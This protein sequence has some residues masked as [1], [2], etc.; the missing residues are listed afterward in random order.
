MYFMLWT[1]Y[2][3]ITFSHLISDCIGFVWHI[4]EIFYKRHTRIFM[5][6]S[7]RHR[8]NNTS[9]LF[10]PNIIHKISP[11]LQTWYKINFSDVTEEINALA[12]FAKRHPYLWKT[13][14]FNIMYSWKNCSKWYWIPKYSFRDLQFYGRIF[15]IYKEFNETSWLRSILHHGLVLCEIEKAEV[16]WNRKV[17]SQLLSDRHII[18]IANKA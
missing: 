4:M 18:D 17:M 7:C 12:A 6:F 13:R 16:E 2:R 15:L 10:L 14:R 9:N 8:E 11:K 3:L 5:I 1:E